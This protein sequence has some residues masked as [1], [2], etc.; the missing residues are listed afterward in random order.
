AQVE[1]LEE[2]KTEIQT[3]IKEVFDEAKAQGLDV[4][5]LKRLISLRKKDKEEIEEQEELLEIYR[6]ALEQ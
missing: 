1:A 3:N 2:K 6:K 5:I 4:Q